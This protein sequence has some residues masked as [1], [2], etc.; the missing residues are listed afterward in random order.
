MTVVPLLGTFVPGMVTSAG[1]DPGNVLFGR[2]RRR[3]LAWFFGHPDE[4]FYLRQILRETEAPQGATQREL[5][6]L[7]AAGLLERTVEG[8]QVYFRVNRGS[9]VFGE[10]QSLV[11]KTAGA[12]GVIRDALTPLADRI[13]AA[14]VFGSAARHE[15]RRDSDIDLLVVGAVSFDE[16]SD[17]LVDV[18]RR[19]GRDVNPTVYPPREYRSKLAAG[20][21]FLTSVISDPRLFVIGDRNDLAGL[22][23]VRVVDDAHSDPSRDPGSAERR[24]TRS[25]KQRRQRTRR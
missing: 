13:L 18:D 8:R 20:H 14:F 1:G 23:R 24:P 15:L 2:T 16:V 5:K 6:A 11:L 9:P 21:H 22:E 10:L 17:R 7:V 25:R 3:L 19:L 4:A 12:V